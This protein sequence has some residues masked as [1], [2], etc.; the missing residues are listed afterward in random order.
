MD[1]IAIG[2]IRTSHG[3]KGFLKVLSFSGETEHFFDLKEFVLKKKRKD[4]DTDCRKYKSLRQ[5]YFCKT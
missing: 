2:K 4:K 5:Y 1:E 3:V